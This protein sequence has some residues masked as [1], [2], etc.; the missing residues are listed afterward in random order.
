MSFILYGT[1][2]DGPHV[3]EVP[4]DVAD[5]FAGSVGGTVHDS[6]D[7]CLTA[8]YHPEQD[9]TA[10]NAGEPVTDVPAPP[11]PQGDAPATEVGTGDP[12]PVPTFGQ[13]SPTESSPSG[14]QR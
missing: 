13:Q 14:D 9:D 1:P 8:W 3:V 5:A 12:T 4:A 7:A 10:D 2:N 11:A 6:V